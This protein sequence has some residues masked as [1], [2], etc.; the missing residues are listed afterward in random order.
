MEPRQIE[1]PETMV[2]AIILSYRENIA[3]HNGIAAT[4]AGQ[5]SQPVSFRFVNM[6][7]QLP[8]QQSPKVRDSL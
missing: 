3:S 5:Y 1:V 6:Q 7:A 4:S 8:F 2:F